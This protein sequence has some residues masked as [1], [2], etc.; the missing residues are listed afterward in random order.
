MTSRGQ[1][2]RYRRLFSHASPA[3]N[4]I[5]PWKLRDH[6][7]ADE[8]VGMYVNDWTLDFGPRGREA[9]ARLLAEGHKA[10][11]IPRLA[12]PEFV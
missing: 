9:V 6:A 5:A 10:G 11:V 8:F 7:K 2:G 1:L 3:S 4:R 12:V